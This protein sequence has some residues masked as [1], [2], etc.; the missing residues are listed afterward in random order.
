MVNPLI[1]IL[2]LISGVAVGWLGVDLLPTK[3]LE[4]VSNINGLR[5]VLAG[6][7]GFFGVLTGFFFQLLRQRLMAQIRNVPTDLLVSRAIGLILGLL[8]ANLL[9]APILLLP[10]PAE[11]V[12]VKPLSAIASNL[13]FG[14]L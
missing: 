6:F 2:F 14:V 1:L 11:M 8:V 10:L 12:F 5:K 13:L 9:L 4:E 3:M 7:G